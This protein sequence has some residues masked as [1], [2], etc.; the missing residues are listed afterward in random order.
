M[1]QEYPTGAELYYAPLT[2]IKNRSI[3]RAELQDSL[4][5]TNLRIT[6]SKLH[7]LDGQSKLVSKYTDY[8]AVNEIKVYGSCFCNGH[9]SR[10]KPIRSV[11]YDK[12]HVGSMFHAVC[13]CEHFSTGD[14]CERCLDMF[15]D[16]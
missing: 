15:N 8:Y 13:Q 1:I 2:Q 12:E 11:Q 3:S 7:V 4:K 6:F 5:V 16:R 14:N 10:C 9:A